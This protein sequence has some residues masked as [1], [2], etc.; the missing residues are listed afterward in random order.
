MATIL[1]EN[2]ADIHAENMWGSNSHWVTY[3][4]YFVG[5]TPLHKAYPEF[6]AV[7]ILVYAQWTRWSSNA[8]IE[9]LDR[10]WSHIRPCVGADIERVSLVCR[11]LFQTFRL[12]VLAEGPLS[13]RS[14][15][16]GFSSCGWHHHLTARLSKKREIW[17]FPNFSE[18]FYHEIRTE[19]GTSRF[20]EVILPKS[21]SGL[22]SQH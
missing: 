7:K 5:Y 19:C 2:G 8:F 11:W 15:R 9:P 17:R 3:H 1:L 18:R 13:E 21:K 14:T 10:V 6:C 16:W 22:L 4:N 12:F 20:C